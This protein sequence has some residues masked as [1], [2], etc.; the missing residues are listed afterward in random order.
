MILVKGQTVK[1]HTK[2]QSGVDDFNQPTYTES[3][4]EV[5]N[6]IIQPAI[7]ED[8]VSNTEINGKHIAYVLHIPKGDTH[9]WK[10]SEVEFYGKTWKTYGDYLEYDSS[11]TP[12]SWN[13]QIKV[14]SYE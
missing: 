1:L 3:V 2:T 10:D 14:E 4:V 9:T 5:E 11:M 8:V 13:K 12:L 7:N 6:V